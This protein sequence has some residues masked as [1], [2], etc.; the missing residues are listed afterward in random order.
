MLCRVC[1]ATL[2]QRTGKHGDFWCCPNSKP[3]ANHG[4]IS[5]RAGLQLQRLVEGVPLDDPDSLMTAIERDTQYFVGVMT[6]LDRFC[7]DP[8]PCAMDDEDAWTSVRPY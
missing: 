4:T 5:C 8:E 7:T 3:G 6:D 2:I 1:K